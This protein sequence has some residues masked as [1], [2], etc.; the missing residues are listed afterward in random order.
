MS[1]NT[2]GRARSACTTTAAR[3]TLSA[4]QERLVWRLRREASAWHMRNLR[5]FI[6]QGGSLN[7]PQWT[8]GALEAREAGALRRANAVLR[9]AT[10]LRRIAREI[11]IR[12]GTRWGP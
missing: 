10:A 11:E 12:R 7:S 6:A 4:A 2:N 8:S 3:H 9:R 5:N 1:S